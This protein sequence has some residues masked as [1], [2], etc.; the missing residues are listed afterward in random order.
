LQK[1]IDSEG[2]IHFTSQ[3]SRSQAKNKTFAQQKLINAVI[4]ALKE[5]KKRKPTRVSKGA[6]EKRLQ[7]KRVKAE[8]KQTRKKVAW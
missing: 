3:E 6:K 4:Q 7:V 5:V 2:I 1:K 8:T